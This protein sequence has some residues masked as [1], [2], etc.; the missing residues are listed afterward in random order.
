[1][2]IKFYVYKHFMFIPKKI[3]DKWKQLNEDGK[4]MY[5]IFTSEPLETQKSK[6]ILIW[7]C[8]HLKLLQIKI[9]QK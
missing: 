1:M 9:Y 8:K 2:F 6:E 5:I 4:V 3:P 7:L